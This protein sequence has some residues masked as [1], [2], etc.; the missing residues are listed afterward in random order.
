MEEI[1]INILIAE[2]TYKLTVDRAG[3]EKVRKA[4]SY[5]NDRVKEYSKAYA[6]KDLQDLVAMAALQFATASLQLEADLNF[7][8]QHLDQ[9]LSDLD[10]ILSAHLG[11]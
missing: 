3:E 6:Y 1:T 9:K 11:S 8:D 5:V 7:K 2:R 10:A 4:A